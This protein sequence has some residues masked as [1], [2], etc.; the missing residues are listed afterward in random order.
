MSDLGGLDLLVNNAST[1]G[2]TPLPHLIDYPL[3]ALSETF[4]VN[5]IAPL[6]MIQALN[7]YLKP[8]ARLINVSSDAGVEP[9]EG[10]GG[11]GASKAAL[12]H[13]SAVL[14]AENPEVL[15]YWVDPGDMRT[16]MQQD[17][18]PGEDISDRPPPEESIPGFL[19]LIE[20]DLPS[21]RYEA[22]SSAERR[23]DVIPVSDSHSS[24]LRRLALLL[25]SLFG[26]D[27]DGL[28]FTLPP[29]LEA[30]E[31][32]EARG[33]SR[34]SVRLMVSR[35]SN[36]RIEHAHFSNLPE[37]LEPG[38][39]LVVNTSG[40]MNAAIKAQR[41]DGLELELHLSTRLPAGIWTAELRLQNG[42]ATI[43]FQSAQAGDRLQ[44][45][46]GGR[47][48]IHAPYSC[49]CDGREVKDGN[50][51][52]LVTLELPS[53][54][55]EYFQ[56]HGFPIRYHY[57]KKQWPSEYYQTVF[58]TETGSAEMPSAGRAFTAEL[59]TRLVSRG[60]GIAP[61]IL[62]TGVASL[63]EGEPPYEEW[64]RV[65]AST[66]AQVN[67]AR[68][69]GRRIVAVGTT[70][71]RALETATSSDGVTYPIEGWTC[72]V[73]SPSKP[74]RSVQGLL[75]GLHEPRSSHLMMLRG[76]VDAEHL[77]LTYAAALDR[78][79]LWHEFGDLHLILP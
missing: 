9:Y 31:P 13:L 4:A 72:H 44:L 54:P 26:V 33:A 63:E 76:L 35:G 43:P 34:D 6:A 39:L 48:V 17:A 50:R 11:Y 71:V 67:V 37:F 32:P 18:F 5:T 10:W 2:A 68:T 55:V 40:T 38:D 75:T 29:N 59:V 69:S 3:E 64:Y 49:G 7:P 58:A 56:Q 46:G 57:V 73:V 65:P 25:T 27:A 61:L 24:P 66:A 77:R 51:L 45:A 53:A 22:G 70:V 52:W 42:S 12:E 8:G 16:R 36:H 62:H 30:S 78:R 21:G 41:E 60:I 79:Y 14:A 20:G 47:A 74:I 19:Q 15:I 23:R 28:E 1:L